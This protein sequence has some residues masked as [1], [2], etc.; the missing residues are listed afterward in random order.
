MTKIDYEA[1][2][3]NRRRVPEHETIAARWAA[4]SAKWR[5]E[6]DLLADQSYGPGERQRYD[7]FRARNAAN[8]PLVVYIH[9]GYW[10]RGDRKAQSFLAKE[11]NKRGIDVALPSYSLAPTVTVAAIV[12]ELR[13][14]LKTLYQ[15]TKKRPVVVGHSAGGHLAAAMLATDWSTVGD[16]PNDLVRAAYALSGA[17]DPEPLIPT[18]LNA[19][20]KL[21]VAS[22]RAANAITGRKP[23][24]SAIMVAA[25]G[26]DESQEFIRQSL[27]LAAAWSAAGVKAECV[28]VPNA[29]HFTM[30][31]ELAR[32]ES[33][34]L[35]R[36]VS[37]AN[38]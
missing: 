27:A 13:Q 8:A 32:P 14:C 16:V 31:D 36:V 2:Y 6:A 37:L 20:L 25:V 35:A 33:A 15:R 18:S 9:G 23:S 19:A 22:A 28:V 10:Q 1:E 30:L 34:V 5:E 24:P 4:A 29:N 26:G 17:F 12:T 3:N 11:F 21:D 7:L 38:S